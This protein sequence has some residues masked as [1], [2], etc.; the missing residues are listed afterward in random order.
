M[1]FTKSIFDKKNLT[2]FLSAI[3][4]VQFLDI[5]VD[6][7]SESSITL[8]ASLDKW[9][10]VSDKGAGINFGFIYGVID[11][12]A[13]LAILN[14]LGIYKSAVT[15]SLKVDHFINDISSNNLYFKAEYIKIKKQYAYSYVTVFDLDG[16]S[17]ANASAAF[18]FKSM[19]FIE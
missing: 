1:N 3:P 4:Y 6:N 14:H 11:T 2:Q 13:Y 5:N 7:I 9:L 12:V 18:L 15:L 17:V 16:K 19:E 10:L 8:R